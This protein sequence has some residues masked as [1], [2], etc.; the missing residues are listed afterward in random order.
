MDFGHETKEIKLLKPEF[1]IQ[2]IHWQNLPCFGF[3]VYK[4]SMLLVE[5]AEK[6][7]MT[8]ITVF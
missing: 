2:S 8:T 1:F 4:N 5:D 3:S 7:E 6:L